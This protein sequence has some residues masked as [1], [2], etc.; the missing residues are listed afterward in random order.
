MSDLFFRNI[1]ATF[2]CSI[3]NHRTYSIMWS[4]ITDYVVSWKY[5]R[6]PN[7]DRIEMIK[8]CLSKNVYVPLYIH[9]GRIMPNLME[10]VCYDGNHRR[11]ACNRLLKQ[12]GIDYCVIIDVIDDT[13]DYELH[14]E[15]RMLSK[16][17]QIPSMYMEK[18]SDTTLR[19]INDKKDIIE[20]YKKKYSSLISQSTRC[21]RPRFNIDLFTEDIDEIYSI[22]KDK[23]IVYEILSCMNTQYKQDATM[24]YEEKIYKL[25]NETNMW[26]FSK[27]RRIDMNEVHRTYKMLSMNNLL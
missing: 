21:I 18:P 2:I 5:N 9:V 19:I 8:D 25:C 26:L 11:E 15:F 14:H 24:L 10:L 13:S 16:S 27:N 6:E 20:T 22:C 23:D 3:N 17:I 1:G 4:K 12:D 7:E